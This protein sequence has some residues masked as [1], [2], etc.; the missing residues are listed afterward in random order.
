MAIKA[1]TINL[2]LNVAVDYTMTH[3]KAH[4]AGK[5]VA[6]PYICTKPGAGKSELLAR[7]C[8]EEGIG[9]VPITVGLI[10]VERFTGIPDFVTKKYQEKKHYLF[11][12]VML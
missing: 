1:T 3:I 12:R 9:F 4:F 6:T 10:R 11:R 7:R 8:A 5:K 2:P